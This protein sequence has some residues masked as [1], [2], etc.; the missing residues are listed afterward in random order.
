MLLPAADSKEA[1]PLWLVSESQLPGFL[2]RLDAPGVAWLAA[3]AFQAERARVLTI[4]GPGGGVAAAIA[5]LGPASESAPSLWDGAAC[6]ER[7]PAG[8]YALSRE[9]PAP[10]ATQFALGWLLGCYR[11][12]RYRSQPKPVHAV[13]L[14][15]PPGCDASYA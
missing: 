8:R 12:T 5:G 9:L 2:S 6:A 15:A 14:V 1:I 13:S 4:P 11:F 7:L 3:H 10:A